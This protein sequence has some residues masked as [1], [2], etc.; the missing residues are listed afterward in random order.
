MSKITP[1]IWFDSNAEEAL[2]LYLSLFS[3]AR[4]LSLNRLPGNEPDSDGPLMMATIELEGQELMMLNGGPHYQLNPA[5]S[6]F[7]SCEDQAEVDR[8]WSVLSDGGQELQCGWVTDRFGVTWQVIPKIFGELMGQSNQEQ[9][10]RVMKA[11]M[12]MKRINIATLIQAHSG[13]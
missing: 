7:V 11:F 2:T 13:V 10:S 4:V 3:N 6:F 12:G 1:F 9:S 5:V 8:L